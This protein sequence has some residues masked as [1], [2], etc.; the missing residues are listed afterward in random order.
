MQNHNSLFL[1]VFFLGLLFLEACGDL[2][3]SQKNR[4][5]VA[6]EMAARKVKFITDEQL[7]KWTDYKGQEITRITQKMLNR[8]SIAAQ[9]NDSSLSQAKLFEMPL[10]SLDTLVKPP[11]VKIEKSS[12]ETDNKQLTDKERAFLK[13]YQ[14][15]ELQLEIQSAFLQGDS[16]IVYTAPIILD[17][18]PQGMWRIYFKKKE[19]IQKMDM[20]EVDSVLKRL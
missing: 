17:G 6:E 13:R 10:A 11:V 7:L 20:K 14:E 5:A 19:L 16:V 3:Q 1:I 9:E 18:K 4:E 15:G 8:A 2:E 12:F